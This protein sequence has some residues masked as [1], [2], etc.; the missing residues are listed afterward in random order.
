ML[1]FSSSPDP[2]RAASEVGGSSVFGRPELSQKTGGIFLF[3]SA[4]TH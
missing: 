1:G 3:E 2:S 4:V